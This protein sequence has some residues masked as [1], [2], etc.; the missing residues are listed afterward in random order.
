MEESFAFGE[1]L[2]AIFCRNVIIYFD[3]ETQERLITRLC[4]VLRPDGYLFLGHSESIHGFD[5]PLK[6]IVSTVHRKIG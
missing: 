3:R 6:R 2:D 1:Q 4:K 5:L